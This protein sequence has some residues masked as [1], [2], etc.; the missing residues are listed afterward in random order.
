M[1][2][3]DRAQPDGSVQLQD[4]EGVLDVVPGYQAVVALVDV[5][6]AGVLA[7]AVAGLVLQDQDGRMAVA[8]PGVDEVAVGGIR[9]PYLVDGLAVV[10]GGFQGEGAV[11]EPGYEGGDW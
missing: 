2:G 7:G 3:Q 11:P 9:A 5:G 6:G 4:L 8:V 10:G 1:C